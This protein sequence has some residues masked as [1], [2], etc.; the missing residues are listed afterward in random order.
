MTWLAITISFALG[1]AV[2]RA[3]ASYAVSKAGFLRW[4]VRCLTRNPVDLEP[5]EFHSAWT[6]KRS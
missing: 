3:R 2:E 4:E 1:I 5:C 6:E